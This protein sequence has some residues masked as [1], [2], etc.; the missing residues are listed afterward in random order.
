MASFFFYPKTIAVIGATNNPKKFGNAV[1]INILKNK[2]LKSKVFLVSNKK[3]EIAG[4][5]CFKSILEIPRDIDIAIILVPAHV[6]NEVINQCIEKKVKG[7]IIVTAGFGEINQEGKKKEL[8]IA[9]KCKEA[10]IRIMG[11]NC[12]GIQ[13]LDINL[14]ASFIQTAPS[15]DISMISQSGSF[16]CASFYAMERVY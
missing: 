15:G 8:E 14:N 16:G 3:E 6:T 12:V 9:S 13:N 7:I 4:L 5:K 2:N 1:T 10:G 11:P